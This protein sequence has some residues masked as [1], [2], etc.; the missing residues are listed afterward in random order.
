MCILI[1]SLLVFVRFIEAS[2]SAGTSPVVISHS[3]DRHWKKKSRSHHPALKCHYFNSIWLRVYYIRLNQ[4]CNTVSFY[5]HLFVGILVFF[6]FSSLSLSLS[7]S[8]MVRLDSAMPPLS[9]IQHRN[10]F[11][12]S[13]NSI[14]LY[15][16]YWNAH[17]RAIGIHETATMLSHIINK[18]E[19]AGQISSNLSS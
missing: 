2:N 14:K 17:S 19:C 12:C 1:F 5:S 8:A 7:L 15:L 3:N 4:L 9:S 18:P 13:E 6:F 10:V 16:Y 11:R